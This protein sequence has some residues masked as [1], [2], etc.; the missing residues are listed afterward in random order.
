T[1]LL[2]LELPG[3]VVAG[4]AHDREEVVV[5]VLGVRA[6]GVDLSL[7]LRGAVGEDELLDR[8]ERVPEALV[9]ALDR[10]ADLRKPVGRVARL[11]VGRR[12][13]AQRSL[14]ARREARAFG[15]GTGDLR[16]ETGEGGNGGLEL[17]RTVAAAATRGR[18]EQPGHE[19][20]LTCELHDSL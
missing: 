20:R 9:Q 13:R 16:G 17:V 4:D 11:D 7:R 8:P 10:V 18:Q 2:D 12:R 3:V 19:E 15:R 6:V 14:G 1:R 5:A